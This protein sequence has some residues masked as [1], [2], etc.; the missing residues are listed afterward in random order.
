MEG[1]RGF[2]V[3]LELALQNAEGDAPVALQEGPRAL[4]GLEEAHSSSRVFRPSLGPRELEINTLE[5]RARAEERGEIEVK[6]LHYPVR[7]YE[8]S[9]EA[10]P[11]A[12]D[13]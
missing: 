10:S 13:G 3:E 4:D 11:V 9:E 1:D 8:V 7:V 6:G 5:S 12:G 2:I